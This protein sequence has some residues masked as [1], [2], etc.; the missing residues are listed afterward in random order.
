[1]TSN[2]TLRR[3]CRSLSSAIAP[4]YVAD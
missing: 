1:M 2:M 4:R 3:D